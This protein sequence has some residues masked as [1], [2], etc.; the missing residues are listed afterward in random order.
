MK[1]SKSEIS[2]SPTSLQRAALLQSPPV[3]GKLFPGT[4]QT[5]GPSAL[6]SPPPPAVALPGCVLPRAMSTARRLPRTEHQQLR[7]ASPSRALRRAQK[8][9]TASG[10]PDA[11]PIS[12]QLAPCTHR[13]W[14]NESPRVCPHPGGCWGGGSSSCQLP[15]HPAA[16]PVVMWAK[17]NPD[18]TAPGCSHRQLSPQK[19][20][21]GMN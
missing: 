17:A 20:L 8:T 1:S 10:C 14:G 19:A 15:V 3:R 2:L 16:L 4:A 12:A 9:P 11:R 6:S 18:Q 5:K 7:A 13:R 21:L